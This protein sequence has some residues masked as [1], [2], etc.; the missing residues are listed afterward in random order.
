MSIRNAGYSIPEDV[1]LSQVYMEIS[2]DP[3]TGAYQSSS[4]FWSRVTDKYHEGKPDCWVSRSARS[5]ECRMKII[6]KA[7]RKLNGCV[8]QIENLNPS[9]ASEQDIVS[10]SCIS[11][12]SIYVCRYLAFNLFLFVGRSRK[13]VARARS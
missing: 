1:L 9:G 2:Q 7:I 6:E 10:I 8:R 5:L 3:I 4:M 11:L 12:L 13:K